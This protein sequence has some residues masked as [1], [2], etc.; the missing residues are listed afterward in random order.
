MWFLLDHALIL[1][2]YLVEFDYINSVT[3]KSIDYKK[4]KEQDLLNEET[5][6]LFQAV[7]PA[8]TILENTYISQATSDQSQQVN[9]HLTCQDLDRSD[10]GSFKKT[11]LDF[12]KQCHIEEL[13]QN[14]NQF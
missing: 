11:L 10:M 1:P 3:K 9:L 13:H 7:T 6:L 12:M 8:S 2:E 14:Q 4:Q 5:N